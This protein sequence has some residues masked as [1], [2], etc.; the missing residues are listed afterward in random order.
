MNEN[1]PIQDS[2]HTPRSKSEHS[3]PVWPVILIAVGIVFLLKNFN[4]VN[5]AVIANT[6]KLWPL[7]LVYLGLDYWTRS[8]P[9]IRT[10]VTILFVSGVV[11]AILLLS[12][13]SAGIWR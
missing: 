4:L 10:I 6:V 9:R 2:I 13:Q 12:D 1:I 7:I 3:S 8:N 5:A 11:F